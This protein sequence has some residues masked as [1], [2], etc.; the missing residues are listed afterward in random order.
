M[1]TSNAAYLNNPKPPYP[2]ISRRLNEQGLV[3]LRVF[4]NTQGQAEKTELY[5]SSGHKRLDDSAQR[6]VAQWRF[7]PGTRNGVPQAMW[8]NVP[9]QFVLE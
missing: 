1:P 2:A 5:Q 3:I 4:I 8:F 6:T 9:I 7:V